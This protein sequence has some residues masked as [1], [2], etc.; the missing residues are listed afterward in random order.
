[1]SKL[2]YDVDGKNLEKDF[3]NG[4]N[5]SLSLDQGLVRYSL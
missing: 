2:N 4:G 1:M 3:K 5:R